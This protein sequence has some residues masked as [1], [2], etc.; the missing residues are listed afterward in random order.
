LIAGCAGVPGTAEV[1]DFLIATTRVVKPLTEFW[2]QVS[3]PREQVKNPIVRAALDVLDKLAVVFPFFM[4]TIAFL[5][6]KIGPLLDPLFRQFQALAA[7]ISEVIRLV[8]FVA[9]GFVELLHR[10]LDPKRSDSVAHYL[11]VAVRAFGGLIDLLKEGLTTRLFGAAQKQLQSMVDGLTAY[12][13]AMAKWVAK[14]FADLLAENPV[15]LMIQRAMERLK[16]IQPLFHRPPPPPPPPAEDPGLIDR[17]I[18]TLKQRAKDAFKY[19]FRE[20]TEDIEWFKKNVPRF[21]PVD[22]E[23]LRLMEPGLYPFSKVVP[24][25]IPPHDPFGTAHLKFRRRPPSVFAGERK[26][27]ESTAIEQVGMPSAAAAVAAAHID[28]TR[29]RE[30]LL[31]VAG[32]VLPPQMQ[33][34]L[35]TLS[36]AMESAEKALGQKPV[37]G[38]ERM[39]PVL[40]LPEEEKL[41]PVVE[42]LVVRVRGAA[43]ELAEEWT[44]GLKVTLRGQVYPIPLEQGGGA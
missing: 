9:T 27:L 28:E 4:A 5:I 34:Y 37:A 32:K 25:L 39:F 41:R 16:K 22:I 1:Q 43:R 3:G 8:S 11:G 29:L 6:G 7:Y 12:F 24:L 19:Q 36:D 31:S 44:E 35:K 18:E 17:I 33:P 15:T 13:D 42:R 38:D 20:I 40:Q 26:A 23:Y 10:L 21:P 2:R 14:R 30:A